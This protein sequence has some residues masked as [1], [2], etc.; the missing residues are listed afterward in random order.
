[1]QLNVVLE[2]SV[3]VPVPRPKLGGALNEPVKVRG[4][5]VPLFKVPP[6]ST[7]IVPVLTVPPDAVKTPTLAADRLNICDV[8]AVCS[9][10]ANVPPGAEEVAVLSCSSAIPLELRPASASMR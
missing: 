7:S 9:R 1:M 5:A 10:K 6:R 8:F 3:N 4:L 2:L